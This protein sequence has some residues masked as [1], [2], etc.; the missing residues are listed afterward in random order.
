MNSKIDLSGRWSFALDNGM[1]G[2]ESKFYTKDFE[3]SI[4]LPT[5][6]SEAKKGTPSD[7]RETGYLTD[8]YA[9]KGYAWFSRE[10][11][12]PDDTKPCEKILTLERTRISHVWVDGEYI[13]TNDS[14]CTSHRYILTPYINSNKHRLTIMTDNASYPVAGGHMTSPDTQ[15]NWNGITGEICI[16]IRNKIR[17]ENIQIYTNIENKSIKVSAEIIGAEECKVKASVIG[18]EEI[19][20]TMSKAK[21]SF[22]YVRGE[23]AEL[24]SE[25]TP[26][27]YTLKIETE[28]NGRTDVYERTFGLREFKANGRYFEI[29]GKATFLRGKH[30]G[31]IFPLTGYA[32]TSVE[33]WLRILKIAKDYGINHYRFH[34]CCPPDA[35]FTAADMLGIYMQPELP[36][37]GTITVDGEDGHDENAQQ[38]LIEQGYKILSEFGNHPSFVMMS[39]GNELWGS[40]EKLNEILGGYKKVDKRHLYTQGS[41]NFQFIPCV[42]ENDDFFSG[43]RFSRD[44]LFRG[45]YA[46]CDAP[47]GHIQT[48]A[49][50]SVHNYN[51]IIRP[52]AVSGNVAQSG[53]IEIQYGTGVKTVSAEASDEFIPNVPAVSHEVGQYNMYPDYN[54][55]EKYTGVLKARSF[56]VFRERL[57]Q[58]GMADKADAFFRASGRFAAECYKQEV[59]T[60]LRTRELAGFQLL[61]LQDFTGQGTALVG[62]LNSFMENKGVISAE[63]WRSFCSQTVIL[64]E[65]DSFVV[66]SGA[67]VKMG[68]KLATFAGEA[69]ENPTIKVELIS[70]ENVVFAAESVTEGEFAND[71]FDLNAI[72]LNIPTSQTAEKLTV[73]ITLAGTN[74]TNSQDIWAFPSVIRAESGNVF[75]CDDLLEAKNALNNGKNVLYFPKKP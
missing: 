72:T 6:V 21:N 40:K 14:L 48:D 46:M 67:K 42:L 28:E 11:S 5:T 30:D 33:E 1:I 22:T 49:P 69:I 10:V 25:H 37:W 39:M 60:A 47:L 38:Y 66:L 44:R 74:V 9:S 59:E 18:F 31:L 17:L 71:I 75:V 57:E 54:E 51:E 19:T 2:I 16:E 55:I 73:K 13:G 36:F 45:S 26:R 65:L 53:L 35:A 4:L 70:D 20:K 24:W 23:S 8:P 68:L 58:K 3:D 27:V 52:N 43:V 15:T 50:N 41:N 62:I 12:F 32:P 64:S 7:V 61:D 34:T 63:E 29:N 56:E